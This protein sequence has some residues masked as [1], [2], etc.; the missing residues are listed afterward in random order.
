[1]PVPPADRTAAFDAP[2]GVPPTS[3]AAGVRAL[4]GGVDEEL[5][6][7]LRSRLILVHLL[8]LAFVVLIAAVSFYSPASERQPDWWLQLVVPLAECLIG[9]AVL[10]RS[11][12]LS[13][14]SLR[15][16]ELAHFGILAAFFGVFRFE[17]LAYMDVENRN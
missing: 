17:R 15:L 16:W 10:W 11:P 8:A 12:G 5:R 2:G 3:L 1:M 13:L 7:L 6:R 4:L 9:A 14:R